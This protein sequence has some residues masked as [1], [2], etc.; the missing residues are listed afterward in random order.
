MTDPELRF[1]PFDRPSWVARAD[2]L[3][4]QTT[5]IYDIALHEFG[6]I[7]QQNHVEASSE[8]MHPLASLGVS[9]TPAAASCGVHVRNVSSS[10]GCNNIP[11][12]SS[13]GGECTSSSV[14]EAERVTPRIWYNP[15][16]RSVEIDLLDVSR[17]QAA[18]LSCHDLN[19]RLLW[20]D[21]TRNSNFSRS[22]SSLPSG[23]YVIST[24]TA[25]W[26]FSTLIIHE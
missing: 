16:T 19:G 21:Q 14:V 1:N 7:L 10:V 12:I 3:A 20:V 6:H 8:L 23:A 13:V 9:L 5:V 11:V 15:T 4:G 17:R 26:T 25:D 22:M 2:R 18:L 24:T